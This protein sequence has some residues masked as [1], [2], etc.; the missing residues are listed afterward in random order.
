MSPSLLIGWVWMQRSAL[1]PSPLRMS[2]SPLVQTSKKL[3]SLSNID[4]S[5]G[6][7]LDFTA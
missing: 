5:S 3:P 7:A 2:I 6:C 1:I 4:M